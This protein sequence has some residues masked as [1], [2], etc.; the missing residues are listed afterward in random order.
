MHI[1]RG[2]RRGFPSGFQFHTAQTSSL[3]TFT[4]HQA[5]ADAEIALMCRAIEVTQE[6]RRAHFDSLIAQVQT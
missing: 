2:A 3:R 1:T 6:A 4:K 5:A